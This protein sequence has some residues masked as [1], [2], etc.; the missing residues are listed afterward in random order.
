MLQ[1]LSGVEVARVERAGNHIV[2]RAQVAG[3]GS[4]C[5]CC[6][7]PGQ[8]VHSRYQRT[9]DDAAIAGTSALIRLRSADSSARTLAAPSERLLGVDDF[10]LRRRHVY[11]TVLIDMDTHRPV[12]LL[13]T[14]KP[15]PLPSGCVSIRGFGSSAGTEPAPGVRQVTSW[16]L[17][18]P[19]NRTPEEQVKLKQVLT[20]CTHFA[21]TA[22]HVTGFAEIMTCRRGRRLDKWIEQVESDD[23][24]H[25]HSFTAG[26]KRD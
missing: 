24:P 9:L 20:N 11:G 15:T 3:L 12:D 8:R 7:R 4:A 23:L 6:G 25:L 19:D 2:V 5:P 26:I 22:K 1:H 18:H 21:A 16:M 10:A 17:R 13:R 14:G